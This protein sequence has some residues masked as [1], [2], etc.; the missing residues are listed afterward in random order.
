MSDFAKLFGAQYNITA[1][2]RDEAA[3]T[4]VALESTN[5]LMYLLAQ[6]ATDDALASFIPSLTSELRESV[7]A[8]AME[9]ARSSSA[10]LLVAQYNASISAS[11]TN[12][13]LELKDTVSPARRAAVQYH[14]EELVNSATQT[15]ALQTLTAAEEAHG[16]NA[17]RVEAAEKRLLNA[18][19]YAMNVRDMGAALGEAGQ[20]FT[21]L[22]A[23]DI[24][25]ERGY[26][27][28][29]DTIKWER[30]RAI[31]DARNSGGSTTGMILGGLFAWGTSKLDD[32]YSNKADTNA[33]YKR[34]GR[35]NA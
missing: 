28:T 21:A 12:G 1:T 33:K 17:K 32:Y 11:V 10:D 7:S 25:D 26:K 3:D 30:D 24:Q 22:G 13:V 15:T 8:L 5:S 16:T 19:S 2:T 6:D 29:A 35:A 20:A 31:N 9:S 23:K 14:I 27:L 4:L 18:V 34:S